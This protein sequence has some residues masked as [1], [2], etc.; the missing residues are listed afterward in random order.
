[1]ITPVLD[2]SAADRVGLALIIGRQ[3]DYT[4][5]VDACLFRVVELGLH[6]ILCEV[7][8][9]CN[10]DEAGNSVGPGAGSKQHL[11]PPHARAN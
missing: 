6:E 9:G 10:A 3:I 7:W 1:M 8:S 5:F 11:L 4:F 2:Q